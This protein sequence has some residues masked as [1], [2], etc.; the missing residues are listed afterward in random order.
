MPQ[1]SGLFSFPQVQAWAESTVG[2]WKYKSFR[3][4]EVGAPSRSDTTEDPCDPAAKIN[5]AASNGSVHDS[6]TAALSH[7]AVRVWG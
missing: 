2:P 1:R 7:V 4:P 3:F 5:V 6:M